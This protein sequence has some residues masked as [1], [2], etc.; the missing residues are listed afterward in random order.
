MQ[1]LQKKIIERKADLTVRGEKLAQPRSYEAE[2]DVEVKHWRK[3]DSD[4]A[5]Y[6]IN[7]EFE[8]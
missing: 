7:Q 6:E 3:R 8:S 5:L 2:A 4:I 1:N